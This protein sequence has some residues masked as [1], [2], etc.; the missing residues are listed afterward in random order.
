MNGKSVKDSTAVVQDSRDVNTSAAEPFV[1]PDVV[2]QYLGIDPGT[3]V[4]FARA[5]LIPGHP[6]RVSGR[7]THWRFLIS[8]IRETMLA[9]NQSRRARRSQ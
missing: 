2:S 1:K 7:R 8:E 3:V 4:R 6:L 9:R 5:G